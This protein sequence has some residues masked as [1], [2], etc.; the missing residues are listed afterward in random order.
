MGQPPKAF[1]DLPLAKGAPDYDHSAFVVAYTK[2]NL[3]HVIYPS[4]IDE[5]DWLD[6]LPKLA[7]ETWK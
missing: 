5:H 1:A 2:E 3:A 6:D 7:K 4:G